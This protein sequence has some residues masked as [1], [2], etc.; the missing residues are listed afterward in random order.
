MP[1]MIVA[2]TMMGP[3]DPAHQS[4]TDLVDFY[5]KWP[6]LRPSVQRL[7]KDPALTQEDREILIWMARLMD[8]ISSADIAGDG[9]P[10]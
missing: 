6:E 3:S 4:I 7:S 9:A 1:T 8:R 10:Q 5:S 2:E